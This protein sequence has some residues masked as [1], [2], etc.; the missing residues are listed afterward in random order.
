MQ[1]LDYVEILGPD[2]HRRTKLVTDTK[3]AKA[4]K[5]GSKR[6]RWCALKDSLFRSKEMARKLVTPEQYCGSHC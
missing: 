3:F 6:W 4:K 1:S 2:R 5:P